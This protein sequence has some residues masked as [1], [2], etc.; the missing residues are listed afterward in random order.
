MKD[1]VIG[2][3]LIVTCSLHEIHVSN[4][5]QDHMSVKQRVREVKQRSEHMHTSISVY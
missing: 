2:R 1:C 3:D 5:F 4:L